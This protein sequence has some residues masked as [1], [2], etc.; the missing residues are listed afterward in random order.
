M[1]RPRPRA[2]SNDWPACRSKRTASASWELGMSRNTVKDYR[3]LDFVPAAAAQEGARR[4]RGLAEGTPAAPSRQCRCDPTPDLPGCHVSAWGAL[5]TIAV[6]LR[7]WQYSSYRP[8]PCRVEQLK[9]ALKA[10]LLAAPR[11]R[12]QENSTRYAPARF[13]CSHRAL[14]ASSSLRKNPE[15]EP[16]SLRVCPKT[17]G[18]IT[19]FSEHE[20]D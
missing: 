20:A 9:A 13:A 14:P 7:S 19:K 3:R 12:P 6:C 5:Y 10:G 18:G 2:I 1:D 17:S 8:G 4:T 11:R 16:C 15:T